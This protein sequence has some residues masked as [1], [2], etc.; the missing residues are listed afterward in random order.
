MFLFEENNGKWFCFVLGFFSPK[1][2]NI[3]YGLDLDW[4]SNMCNTESM[5]SGTLRTACPPFAVSAAFQLN[6]R[7]SLVTSG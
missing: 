3:K 5:L 2:R 4:F 1:Q 6:M 7:L